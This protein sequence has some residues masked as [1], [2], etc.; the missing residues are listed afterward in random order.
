MNPIVHTMETQFHGAANAAHLRALHKNRDWNG[1]LDY[2]LLL[3]EAE[4]SGISK[5]QWLIREANRDNGI[6]QWH[7]DLAAKLLGGSGG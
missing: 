1:L 3:A 6:Q 2:A 7:Q 5:I 4:A